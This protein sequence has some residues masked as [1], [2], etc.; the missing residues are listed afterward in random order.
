ME[1]K[2]ALPPI[3]LLTPGTANSLKGPCLSLF[4]FLTIICHEPLSFCLPLSLGQLCQASRS[5][6]LAATARPHCG[7][8]FTPPPTA[9]SGAGQ[10]FLYKIVVLDAPPSPVH[11]LSW[12]LDFFRL[13]F[14][15]SAP[16]LAHLLS[17][18]LDPFRLFFVSSP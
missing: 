11:D 5:K 4:F 2:A 3:H 12:T 9:L 8:R 17:W 10:F 13:F 16:R 15:P 18:A 14:V 6:L 7:L 1:G